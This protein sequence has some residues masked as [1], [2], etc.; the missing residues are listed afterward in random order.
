MEK[1]FID[2]ILKNILNENLEKGL[3]LMLKDAYG[4]YVFILFKVI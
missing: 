4:N 3:L 2:G 1:F